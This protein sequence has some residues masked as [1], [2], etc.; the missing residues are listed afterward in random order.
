MYRTWTNH[1]IIKL[2]KYVFFYLCWPIILFIFHHRSGKFF[3][4]MNLNHIGYQY[5]IF[6]KTEKIKPLVKNF[7]TKI[8]ASIIILGGYFVITLTLGLQLSVKCKGQWD[9]ESVF[10]C[11]TH[12]HKWE[13]MQGMEPNDSQVHS[14]FGNHT[15]VRVTNVQHLGWKG[16]QTSNWAPKTPLKN[17]SHCSFRL[18]LHELWSKEGTWI[19]LGIW[20]PNTNPL[21][22]GVKWALIG[23]CYT[24][25][26]RSFWRL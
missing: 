10:G 14:H 6:W 13:K 24:P 18:N 12:F 3:I 1:F 5:W 17:S 8:K 19:K 11:E 7:T 20:L 4:N 25:L 22:L 26:E 9:Q 16:K 15:H 2:W 21:K 23:A